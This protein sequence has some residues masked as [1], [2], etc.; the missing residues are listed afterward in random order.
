MTTRFIRYAHR[1]ATV[2]ESILEHCVINVCDVAPPAPVN[3][4]VVNTTSN[5]AL[6]A[7]QAPNPSY[8]EIIAYRVVYW[9]AAL[10]GTSS[11][12]LVTDVSTCQTSLVG[13]SPFTVYT[14]QVNI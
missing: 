7:W 9:V 11:S 8:G 6:L 12:V 1:C 4:H 2:V 5:G 3:V 13:L 14:V 10:S